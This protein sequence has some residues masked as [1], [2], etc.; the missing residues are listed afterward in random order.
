MIF[1]NLQP[2]IDDAI[3]S[4]DKTGEPVEVKLIYNEI[5][6]RHAM[7]DAFE[8]LFWKSRPFQTRYDEYRF[9]LIILPENNKK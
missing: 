7:N 5:G 1:E 6:Y 8:Y 4:A 2:R 3:L 9:V